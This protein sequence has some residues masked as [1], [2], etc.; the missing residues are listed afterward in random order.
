MSYKRVNFTMEE[1]LLKEA[2]AA[3]KYAHRTSFSGYLS[4]LV[5][6]DIAKRPPMAAT[7]ANISATVEVATLLREL[8]AE[9]KAHQ[10][11][12]ANKKNPKTHS[13]K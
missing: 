5:V 13:R 8:S 9:M 6:E 11:A 3:A 10:N 12:P 1:G 4:K 2:K 7:A